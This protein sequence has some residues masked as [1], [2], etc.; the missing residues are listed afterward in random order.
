M[1]SYWLH[2]NRLL[3]SSDF[4][5]TNR[6]DGNSFDNGPAPPPPP[7]TSPPPGISHDK[8]NRTRGDGSDSGGSHSSQQKKLK[9]GPIIGIVVGSIVVLVCAMLALVFCFR[10][11]S[12][13]KQED[14]RSSRDFLGALSLG[15]DKGNLHI[16][17]FTRP[18]FFISGQNSSFI[19]YNN[20]GLLV[21]FDILL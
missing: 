20:Y 3:R 17:I 16:C 15:A 7:Y 4:T 6:S 5:I 18:N 2:Y 12:K 10:R 8:H 14:E 13:D 9:V 1:Y 21:L 19:H 11:F